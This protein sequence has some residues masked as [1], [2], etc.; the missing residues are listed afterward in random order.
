MT[1]QALKVLIQHNMLNCLECSPAIVISGEEKHRIYEISAYIK[2]PNQNVNAE[3]VF[4][5][6]RPFTEQP[7]VVNYFTRLGVPKN[8][9][10]FVY[11]KGSDYYR[12]AEQMA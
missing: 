8:K 3:L 12:T 5:T 10:M 11:P 9:I 2:T 4:H 7:E 6:D 1:P